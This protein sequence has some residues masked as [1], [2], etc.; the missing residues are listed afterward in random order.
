MI[1]G[2]AHITFIPFAPPLGYV[3][4]RHAIVN[5]KL[6]PNPREKNKFMS[7]PAKYHSLMVYKDSNGLAVERIYYSG[8]REAGLG[9]YDVNNGCIVL[10]TKRCYLHQ[11]ELFWMDALGFKKSDSGCLKRIS[12]IRTMSAQVMIKSSIIKDD[13]FIDSPGFTSV[14]FLVRNIRSVYDKVT[15]SIYKVKHTNIFKLNAVGLSVITAF[16]VKTPSGAYIEF[17]E[18]ENGKNN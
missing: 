3:D 14:A 1:I 10:N 8:E 5:K 9:R 18:V 6:V 12:P 7:Y 15:K 16:L 13:S 11:E 2:L 17:F 4:L